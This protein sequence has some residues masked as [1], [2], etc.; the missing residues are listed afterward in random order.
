MTQAQ[1]GRPRPL[2]PVVP[3]RLLRTCSTRTEHQ[4][5]RRECLMVVGR[6]GGQSNVCGAGV[7]LEATCSPL[8]SDVHD[9]L[10]HLRPHTKATML[11]EQNRC[12][13]CHRHANSYVRQR[14]CLFRGRWV[15]DT[16]LWPHVSR[17]QQQHRST[18][19]EGAPAP[20]LQVE[21]QQMSQIRGG[22]A[23]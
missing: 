21:T 4:R 10:Q 6:D 11:E 22:R 20:H 3:A 16:N 2:R 7:W 17:Q 15:D 23:E 19:S 18:N 13:W 14:R 12:R 9:I 1:Q 5:L 8:L